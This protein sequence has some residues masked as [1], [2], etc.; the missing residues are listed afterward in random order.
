MRATVYSLNDISNIYGLSYV[1]KNNNNHR[2][3]AII[4]H[5]IPSQFNAIQTLLSLNIA[6]FQPTHSNFRLTLDYN[7]RWWRSTKKKSLN[8]LNWMGNSFSEIHCKWNNFHH[9][10]IFLAKC[11]YMFLYKFIILV[12]AQH[13][14]KIKQKSEILMEQSDS[15]EAIRQ[16][17]IG[18]MQ[19]KI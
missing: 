12:C 11:D 6:V 17:K 16:R 14:W 19:T 10:N 5:V 18:Q 13:F 4:D 3:T 2:K 7:K 8:V 9:T 1:N 15:E